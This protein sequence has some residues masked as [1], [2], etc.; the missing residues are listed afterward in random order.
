MC[1]RLE[2][3]IAFQETNPD[4]YKR[5][6]NASSWLVL[7]FAGNFPLEVYLREVQEY[8]V[9]G[10]VKEAQERI[11]EKLVQVVERIEGISFHDGGG[12]GIVALLVESCLVWYLEYER[13]ILAYG[14][15]SRRRKKLWQQMRYIFGLDQRIE[16]HE[17]GDYEG[18]KDGGIVP[19]SRADLKLSNVVQKLQSRIGRNIDRSKAFEEV[20]FPPMGL[21]SIGP[22]NR[23][24]ILESI[25]SKAQQALPR[26]GQVF[27]EVGAASIRDTLERNLNPMVRT[28]CEKGFFDI[29]Q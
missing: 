24:E 1:H 19:D 14:E 27:E 22:I 17:D 26:F 3:L 18:Y 12:R 8:L 7:H 6:P 25:I 21:P 9:L 16:E 28:I 10:A 29:Q 4:L 15:L 23:R 2:A 11:L 20:R 5:T 13:G